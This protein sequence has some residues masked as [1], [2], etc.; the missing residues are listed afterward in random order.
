MD[1]SQVDIPFG[2]TATTDI[3]F[4]VVRSNKPCA[5]MR[6][7]SRAQQ[8][9]TETEGCLSTQTS[10]ASLRSEPLLTAS[11]SQHAIF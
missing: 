1:Q 6:A 10:T 4:K 11:R 8:F 3:P 5:A 7:T 9:K 2:Q